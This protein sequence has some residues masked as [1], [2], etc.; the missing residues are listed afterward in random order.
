M[1]DADLVTEQ[2]QRV[3]DA[4]RSRLKAAKPKRLGIHCVSC[5]E[6]IPA[7]RRAVS[8]SCLC[9][10]CLDQMERGMGR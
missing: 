3:E 6:E 1:D 8:D 2:W 5:G 10:D 4:S 7:A 9:V